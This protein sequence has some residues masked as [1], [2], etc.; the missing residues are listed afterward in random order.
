M[1]RGAFVAPAAPPVRFAAAVRR[2]CLK[3]VSSRTEHCRHTGIV[4]SGERQY[5]G[6]VHGP[7]QKLTRATRTSN[8]QSAEALTKGSCLPQVLSAARHRHLPVRERSGAG[9][10]PAVGAGHR[11]PRSIDAR[12]ACGSRRT[13]GRHHASHRHVHREGHFVA[14]HRARDRTGHPALHAG[15]HHLACHR[16]PGLLERPRHRPHARLAHE[17]VGAHRTARV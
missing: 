9:I 8:E 11:R 12:R 15:K 13:S 17:A 14:R 3:T 5:D 7:V 6:R 10:R 16:G 1:S 2:R 4:P